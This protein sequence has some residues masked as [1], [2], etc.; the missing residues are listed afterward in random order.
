MVC[1]AMLRGVP[2]SGNLRLAAG[3]AAMQIDEYKDSGSNP[4][5]IWLQSRALGL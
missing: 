1:L 5:L 2:T 4:F 3:Q